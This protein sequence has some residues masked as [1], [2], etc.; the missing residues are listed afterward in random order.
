MLESKMRKVWVSFV[1]AFLCAAQ[2]S[3]VPDGPRLRTDGRLE[4]PANYREWIW[5]SSGLGMSYTPPAQSRGGAGPR[6]DNVFVTPAA[7]RAFL[8]TGTWPDRTMFVLEVR[9]AESQGSINQQG[10]YQGARVG[11]E[12]EVKDERVPGKWSFFAFNGAADSATPLPRSA[13][14]YSC[15]A[16]NGAVDNT[17][18][19]FYPTL[20][21]VA[22]QKGT[23]K[24]VAETPVR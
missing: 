9:A 19:Q 11:M 21:E 23:W 8:Q 20:I 7:Y 1:L 5:L 12:A 16:Q 24:P 4:R 14:C 18:V 2:P 17:F 13:A 15:H 10:H 6:F 22:K 3:A